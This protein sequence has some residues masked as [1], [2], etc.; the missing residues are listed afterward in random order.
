MRYRFV[1]TLCIASLLAFVGT[2]SAQRAGQNMTVRT[3][4]V[5]GARSVDLND[6]SA[7]GGAIVGGAI[8]AA[9]TRSSKG[10]RRR[11]RNAAIGAVLGGA[12]AAS[13]TRPGKVYS[14]RISG[15]EVINIATEQT[16]IQ[17]GDCVLVEQSSNS[18]N[19]R[20]ASPATCET[21]SDDVMDE[22]LIAE[23]LSDSARR[24]EAAKDSL[25][26][27]ETDEDIDRAIRRIEILCYD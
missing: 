12:R 20:R 14:V 10:S 3:G 21:A 1:I 5:E 17:I 26:E 23:E 13:S 24:C 25:I 6:R 4:I 16:E 8:G 27:A 9:V 18:A 19:I 2:A 22:P 15:N 7:L 11:D